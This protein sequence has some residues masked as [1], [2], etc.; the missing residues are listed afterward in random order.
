[1]DHIMM[2][3]E[4]VTVH[5]EILTIQEVVE[6]QEVVVVRLMVMEVEIQEEEVRLTI[7]RIQM[8]HFLLKG[9]TVEDWEISG[10]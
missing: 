2:E 1:M 6:V 7:L 3:E 4:E 8:R 9:I 10:D 5:Q